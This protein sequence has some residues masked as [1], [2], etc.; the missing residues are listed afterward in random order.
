M[1]LGKA[2]TYPWLEGGFLCGNVPTQSVNVQWLC[3]ENWIWSEHG[4]CLLLEYEVS[5]SI[6]GM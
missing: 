2:I 1:T 5:H 3:W 6:G 4:L